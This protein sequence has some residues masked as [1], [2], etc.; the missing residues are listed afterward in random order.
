MQ[1]NIL[2][3]LQKVKLNAL[4]MVYCLSMFHLVRNEFSYQSLKHF[5]KKCTLNDVALK[6]NSNLYKILLSDSTTPD[7]DQ[8]PCSWRLTINA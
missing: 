3:P 6:V 2:V 7:K 5:Y 4:R 8:V 1:P